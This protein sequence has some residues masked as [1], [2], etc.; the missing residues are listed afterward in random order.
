MKCQNIKRKLVAYLDREVEKKQKLLI[1]EHLSQCAEC[2]K[3]A[4]LLQKTFYILKDQQRLKS[5]ADFEAHLWER[6]HRTKERQ[7]RPQAIFERLDHLILPATVAVAL[8]VG[9]VVG[10]LVEK[11][12]SLQM[13]KVQE[14]EYVTSIGLDNFQDFPPG[15]LP[16]IYFNLASTQEV[17]K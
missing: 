3:E 8:I 10:N 11:I 6:I 9:V 4:D 13:L 1:K 15:S 12:T 16:E 17:E 7:L 5:S 14:E 2:K